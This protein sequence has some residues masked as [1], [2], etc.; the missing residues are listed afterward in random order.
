LA[1]GFVSGDGTLDER[2]RRA[3]DSILDLV[4]VE[5]CIRDEHGE[6]VDFEIVWMNNAPIDVAG[7]PREE[8]IGQRISEMYPVLAGGELIASYR[9]VMETGEPLVIPTMAYHDVIDGKDV[10]G[11]YTVQATK[12][13]DGV[14]VASRDI[15]PL[16]TSRRELE[17][18]LRELEAAQ[19]L[20]QLGTW[21]VDL[22]TLSVALS[23]ELQRLFSLPGSGVGDADFRESIHPDDRPLLDEAV[24]RAMSSRTPTA[25]EHRVLRPSGEILYVRTY[26]EPSLDNDEVVGLWGTTQDVTEAIVRRA[27]YEVEHSRRESAE[28]VAHLASSLNDATTM[29]DIVDAVLTS[30][31][32][33]GDAAVAVLALQEANEP[34]LFHYFAGDALG[35]DLQARYR[36][37]PLTVATHLT[38][39]VTEEAMLLFR[40]RASQIAAFPAIARDIEA[41][42]LE[43]VAV[44]PLRRAS[45]AMFGSLAMAWHSASDFDD[46]MTATFREVAT[47]VGRATER[48]ELLAL[49]RS[50]AETLQLGL[51]AFDLRSTEAVV[52]A[53]YRASDA[54]LAAG[55][56]WYD[57]IELEDGRI[58]IAVG[59]VVGQGLTAAT[60]MGQLRAALGVTVMYAN[61]AAD[62]I[63]MLDRYA[64]HVPGA[65][66]TTVALAIVDTASQTLAYAVAGHPPPVIVTPDGRTTFLDDGRA[67]PLGIRTDETRSPAAHTALPPGSLVLMYTDG[68]VE[69]RGESVDVGLA[70]LRAVVEEHWNLPLRRLK[71]AIFERLVDQTEIAA[72]DDIALVA[73]RTCGRSAAH[74]VDAIR[75][76]AAEGAAVRRRLRKWLTDV[77]VESS[78]RDVILLAVGEAVANAI[79]H[80]ARRD[81]S[82]VVTI[83][84]AERGARIVAAV[85]DTGVWQSGVEG[86]FTGRGRGHQIMQGLAD[87]V[88]VE[89]DQHGTIVILE[90]STGKRAS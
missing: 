62:A 43:S 3:L 68:L 67:W 36:R 56:D 49:E 46:V 13:E 39:A 20:A 51:L 85:S 16:E 75:A 37:T 19:R 18:A 25:L 64:T 23:A 48:L 41:S 84:V 32:T 45:G 52:R 27:A 66:C 77:G 53:R 73:V 65:A 7:R 79:D 55:G 44:V 87:D 30:L 61:D 90:L 50:I 6:I 81:P 58:A 70:R 78:E 59:D 17:L 26:I 83:E 1:D 9:R 29:Q 31:Q 11:Y 72:D 54:T 47:I 38:R 28:T 86:F 69:R 71:N 8:L 60:A 15:T 63:T 10:S 74:F 35:G 57:A 88:T 89:S 80:G 82:Q 2:F 40:D 12:F 34:M 14:L 33:S 21:R 24:A 4:V 5:R 22:T 76:E 42:A